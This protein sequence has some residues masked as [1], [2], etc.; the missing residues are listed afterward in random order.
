MKR[1]GV[2]L[3][4][5]LAACGL[6]RRRALRRAIRIEPIRIVVPFAPGG[7][8]DVLARLV[9]SKLSE[10]VR[11]PVVVDH[12][13]GAGGNL[14]ADAVAKSPPDGYTILLAVSGLAVSPALYRTL[15]FDPVKDFVPVTE[16]DL[17]DTVARGDAQA[18]GE[19]GA[20]A[21]RARQI[22]AGQPELRLERARRPAASDHGDLQEL[23]RDRPG[24]RAV[25]RRCAAQCRADRRHHRSCVRA[26]ADRF[27]AR[28]IRTAAGARRP[29]AP[30]AR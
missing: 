9:G 8:V 4:V 18:A 19:V 22:Q 11:Q 10:L 14:G 20:R 21:H 3:S 25:P 6:A 23:G 15:P 29:P 28:S 26:A 17:L 7:G 27:A 16:V 12:R 13:P 5:W 24:A 30:G 1:L 2:A